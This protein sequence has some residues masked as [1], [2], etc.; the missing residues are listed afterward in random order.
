MGF[1]FGLTGKVMLAAVAFGPAGSLFGELMY[2][3]KDFFK[4]VLKND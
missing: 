2:L 3:V 1:N 4:V